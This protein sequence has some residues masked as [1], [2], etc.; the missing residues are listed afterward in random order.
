MHTDV[1]V[2]GRSL[3][4]GRTIA[5][6]RLAAPAPIGAYE[7]WLGGLYRSGAPP[8]RPLVTGR[9]GLVV[10]VSIGAV[11]VLSVDATRWPRR[12]SRRRDRADVSR[13]H[14]VAH[15][16]RDH[17]SCASVPAGSTRPGRPGS[18]ARVL[19]RVHRLPA[20]LGAGARGARPAVRGLSVRAAPPVRSQTSSNG[21]RLISA[22]TGAA[23]APGTSSSPSGSL[24][25]PATGAAA[26]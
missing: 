7:A 8:R 6:A 12:R 2:D 18:R 22:R 19:R 20:R 3:L 17:R 16:G 21:N 11:V 15:L 1:F 10:A 26:T 24:G 4:D 23:A 25:P 14:L 9:Q 13:R 5:E